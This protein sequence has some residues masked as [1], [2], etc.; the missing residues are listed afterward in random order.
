MFNKL[1]AMVT[2][3]KNTVAGSAAAGRKEACRFVP[4]FEALE[5]RRLMAASVTLAYYGSTILIE[6]DN[7]AN[8]VSVTQSRSGYGSHAKDYVHVTADGVTTSFLNNRGYYGYARIGAIEFNGN[9]GDDTFVNN[10]NLGSLARG[11]EGTDY[12]YGGYSIDS[13]Y[14]DGGGDYLYGGDSGDSLFGGGGVD[15]LFGQAGDDTLDGGDD[16]CADK[17]FGGAGF[18]KFQME[19]RGVRN[20]PILPY[21]NLD[22]PMDF[23]A[24]EDSF[25][26]ED[27]MQVD[28]GVGGTG[29]GRPFDPALESVF[30][31]MSL[32]E[33]EETGSPSLTMDTVYVSTRLSSPLMKSL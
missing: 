24:L 9:W 12:L 16:S 2:V 17:L 26:G 11:G 22:D 29:G 32:L 23:N 21:Y 10:T 14:G 33:L 3:V 20:S 30:A 25:Y 13:L 19:G 4:G 7:S 18:D 6:G 28:G 5:D 27:P 31:D 1:S 8:T 15:Y